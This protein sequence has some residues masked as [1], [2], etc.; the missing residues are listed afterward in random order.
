ME[1]RSA[2]T[3]YV[4]D[5]TVDIRLVWRFTGCRLSE[6]GD[7]CFGWMGRLPGGRPGTAATVHAVL[8]FRWDEK[9]G[10]LEA[11][12][13]GVVADFHPLRLPVRLEPIPYPQ[14]EDTG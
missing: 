11:A 3:L 14:T 7:E 8:G 2:Y 5:S 6:V 9:K 10:G 4:V 1:S 13:L 12:L